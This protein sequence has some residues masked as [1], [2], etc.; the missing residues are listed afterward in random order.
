MRLRITLLFAIAATVTACGSE[1][2][3]RIFEEFPTSMTALSWPAAF[4]PATDA[5]AW[6]DDEATALTLHVNGNK[7]VLGQENASA[8]ISRLAFTNDG[9]YLV[10]DHYTRPAETLRVWDATTGRAMSTR[11]LDGTFNHGNWSLATNG[12]YLA[13][14]RRGGAVEVFAL[15]DL[16]SPMTRLEGGVGDMAEACLSPDGARVAAVDQKGSV[17][18][19]DRASRR[20][21]ARVQIPRPGG[22]ER[23]T[24]GALT[25]SPDGRQVAVICRPEDDESGTHLALL[26]GTSLAVR[27]QFEIVGGSRG[28]AFSPDGKHLAISHSHNTPFQLYDVERGIKLESVDGT[29]G[30]YEIGFRTISVPRLTYSPKGDRVSTVDSNGRV[31]VFSRSP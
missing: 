22:G 1:S 26:D 16:A 4:S 10:S 7:H 13:Y 24:P 5:A 20:E 25:F 11:Q 30:G 14:P 17:L 8:S 21:L 31:R 19:W 3:T 23:D 27:R 28:L 9:R 29:L 2:Q 6:G 12:R 15:P 18:L